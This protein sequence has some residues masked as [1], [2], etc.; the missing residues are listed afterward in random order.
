MNIPDSVKVSV[1]SLLGVATPV[2]N[3]FVDLGTPV[4]NFLLLLAQLAVATVTAIYIYTKWRNLK[5]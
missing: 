5:K 2:S 3:W 1:A 4:L